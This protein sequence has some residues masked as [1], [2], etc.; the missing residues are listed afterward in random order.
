MNSKPYLREIPRA[1]WYLA[2]RR[3][4]LHML[5]EVSSIF[6]GA[7]AILLLL[8]LKALADGAGAYEVYLARLASPLSLGFHWLAL[9]VTL[10]NS[11]SWFSLTPKAMPLQIG[12]EFVPGYFIVAAHYIAWA[13]VSLFI[14]YVAGVFTH[15]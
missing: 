14:L 15:G 2:R 6:I 10:Y 11:F 9:I 8:G 1:T 7:Y 12:E 13:A 5:T 3:D 4:L